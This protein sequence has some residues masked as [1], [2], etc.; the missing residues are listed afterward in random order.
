[1][2]TEWRNCVKDQVIA[3]GVAPAGRMPVAKDFPDADFLPIHTSMSSI[4]YGAPF[5]ANG[6]PRA[7]Y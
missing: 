2:Y 4:Q 3:R 1:M 7:G 6:V 5:L